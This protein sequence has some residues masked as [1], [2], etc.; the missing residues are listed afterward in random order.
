M[1][2]YLQLLLTFCFMLGVL[3][4]TTPSIGYACSCVIPPPPDQALQQAEAVFAGKVIGV[5]E[6]SQKYQKSVLF[7]VTSTW[8]G[9]TQTQVEL[10]TP[11]NSAACGYEFKEGQE[12]LVYANQGEAN[13]LETNLCTR[14]TE[15]SS[16]EEDLSVLG[17]GT[18]PTTEVKNE[19]VSKPVNVYPWISGFVVVGIVAFFVWRRYRR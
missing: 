9:V 10:T 7:E 4:V 2:K 1:K 3:M 18:Q 13:Q 17:E 8:K 12:Y 19:G 11:L 6:N 15:F 5:K 16:A 14:T